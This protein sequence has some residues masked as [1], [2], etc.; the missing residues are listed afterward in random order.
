MSYNPCEVCGRRYRG[1][2]SFAYFAVVN[3]MVAD[4]RRVRSCLECFAA[5]LSVSDSQLGLV[6]LGD[7]LLASTQAD[8]TDCTVCGDPEAYFRVFA[9]LYPHGEA[10]RHYSAARCGRHLPDVS[11]NASEALIAG[12]QT[13]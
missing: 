13:P 6:Q 8:R 11:Q 5:L 9:D 4:R 10:D 1:R 7:E 2:A 12:R 3:G